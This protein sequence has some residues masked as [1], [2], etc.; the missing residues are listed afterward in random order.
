MR[1]LLT[2][3]ADIAGMALTTAGVALWS[4]PAAL[5]V[6]GGWCLVASWRQQ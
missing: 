3:T 4:R 5:I 2:T 1:H 6:A